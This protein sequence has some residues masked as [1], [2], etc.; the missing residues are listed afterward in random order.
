MSQR[1]QASALLD[2]RGVTKSFGG[3]RAVDHLS[4]SL[5]ERRSTSLIGPNGAGKTTVFNLITGFLACDT[6]DV[7]FKGR[8]ISGLPPHRIA[9]RGIARSFQDLRLFSRM[10]VLDTVLLVRKGQSG[11]N[12][13][14]AF[15]NPVRV[16]REE[17]E[18]REA[19]MA[20][21]EFVGLADR[22]RVVAEDLSF[23]E[24][25]LLVIAR[26]LATEAECL[27]LDEPMSGLDVASA[28]KMC[29]MVRELIDRGKSVCL[30]EHN[31][32]IVKEASDWIVFLDQGQVVATGAPD[33][34]LK[35][36]K[37][38]EIYFGT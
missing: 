17:R 13:F 32:D 9:R 2:V 3:I 24:Q 10:S 29:G 19:A 26:L 4:L 25:K 1:T 36:R 38:A 15:L 28:R 11:E 5:E 23:A 27:L 21:L 7:W 35:D 30:I 22:A 8:R 18:N 33:E 12:L 16:A 6:G 34:I 37:L 31:L 14:Q 20:Y